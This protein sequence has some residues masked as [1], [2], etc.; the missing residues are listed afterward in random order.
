M[1]LKGNVKSEYEISGKARHVGY[2]EILEVARI[3]DEAASNANECA[4]L[5][6]EAAEKANAVFVNA[7]NL[8]NALKKT[9]SGNAVRIEDSSTLEHE[10]K[11]GLKSKNLANA[12]A[13]LNANLIKDENGVY[14]ITKDGSAVFRFD[15][16]IPANTPF[17][18]S[19]ENFE[20]YNANSDAYIY[21]AIYFADG[22]SQ[23]GSWCGQG[24]FSNNIVVNP[25]KDVKGFAIYMYNPSADAY[26]SFTGVQV[27]LGTTATAYTP[28]VDVNGASVKKY[29]KSLLSQDALY[30]ANVFYKQDDGRWFYGK[31][32]GSYVSTEAKLTIPA[33]TKFTCSFEGIDVS[34]APT[35]SNGD[36]V[37]LQVYFTDRTS[38]YPGFPKSAIEANGKVSITY[39]PEKQV[40]GVRFSYPNV[41]KDGNYIT[42]DS[43][44]IELGTIATEHED[45]KDPETI[46]AEEDGT[47][48]GIIGNGDT[49]TLVA[50]NSV[51]ITAE[52]NRDLNKAFAEIYQ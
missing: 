8:S 40:S 46:T 26:C 23:G 43:F 20:G 24:K 3:A 28:Y 7:G 39:Y 41:T 15:E 16:T 31:V 44:R 6:Y 12:D 52:Y 17:V 37:Q 5:A 48:N 32:N 29:G 34:N 36:F 19:Y 30:R 45:Y 27:E 42:F 1:S 21:N 14:R 13:M 51:I 9:V 18:I 25:G 38:E 49:V 50:D 33:N 22:T 47:V 11:V 35:T 2:N 4:E 10:M